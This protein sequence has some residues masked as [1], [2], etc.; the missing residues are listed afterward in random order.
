MK[1]YFR[2]PHCNSLAIEKE[3]IIVHLKINGH[4]FAFNK[5]DVYLNRP[6]NLHSLF[7]ELINDIRYNDKF[8]SDSVTYSFNEEDYVACYSCKKTFISEAYISIADEF[9]FFIEDF[10]LYKINGILL[11]ELKITLSDVDIRYGNKLFFFI[12]SLPE[13]YT[14][15]KLFFEKLIKIREELHVIGGSGGAAEV[16]EW[17]IEQTKSEL[18]SLLFSF[19]VIHGINKINQ[20]IESKVLRNK[21]KK[22]IAD[23]K[24]SWGDIEFED[25]L[26]NIEFPKGFKGSKEEVIVKI[27]EQKTA[28][29]KEQLIETI[30]KKN[31]LEK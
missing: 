1:R 22:Y 5:S 26:K 24:K 19:V 14:S 11:N 3:P 7:S 8:Y 16:L 6:N 18:F 9:Y 4:S 31:N 12:D 20:F 21:I 28:I 30:R 15:D 10:V 27:V 2:C 13:K 23:S 29:Y 25:L 17:I